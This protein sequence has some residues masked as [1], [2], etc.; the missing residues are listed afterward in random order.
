MHQC[1]D[2]P[3][4]ASFIEGMVYFL[5]RNDVDVQIAD[6]CPA[7]SNQDS[8]SI[9]TSPD[10][11]N[12]PDATVEGTVSSNTVS[13]RTLPSSTDENF[14]LD[15]S[16]P[17]FQL[18]NPMATGMPIEMPLI[19][20]YGKEPT[21]SHNTVIVD[22][23]GEG[24]NGQGFST[25]LQSDQFMPF[26]NMPSNRPFVN[27]PWIE[28][29]AHTAPDNI[30]LPQAQG[31][32]SMEPQLASKDTSPLCD[33]QASMQSLESRW[34]DS[35]EA[36]LPTDMAASAFGAAPV[37]MGLKT[38]H[39]GQDQLQYHS[40]SSSVSDDVPGTYEFSV[41]S[42]EI[43]T[44]AERQLDESQLNDYGDDTSQTSKTTGFMVSET[45]SDSFLVSA[46]SRPRAASAAQ[47]HSRPTPLALQSVATVRKRKPR[48]S[49]VSVDQSQSKPLQI[50]QEDGQGGSIASA[51]FVS[52][53]RGARRKGPLSMAGRANAGMRRKNKDTCVQCR[54]NKRKVF[55]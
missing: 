2:S 11:F 52:P 54:L 8:T 15:E 20:P 4:I 13:P 34:L 16:W 32:L 22:D 9:A 17:Q 43:P 14:Q 37:D 18:L 47:R 24:S 26:P 49:T 28:M 10:K 51:D 53:P 27:E 7:G 5:P 31:P 1:W 6:G 41:T 42:D 19:Y 40:E 46:P 36:Q 25:D 38:G 48:S 45:P 44:F 30:S 3:G 33:S 29:H 23:V 12:L 39:M 55:H 21:T 50:V 35:L